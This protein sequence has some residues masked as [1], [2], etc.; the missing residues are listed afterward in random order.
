[1]KKIDIIYFK[2]YLSFFIL[3]SLALVSCDKTKIQFGQA[4]VDN[5]YSNIILV[6]TLTTELSTVYFDSLPTSGSGIMLVG[7]YNDN[8]F[9]KVAAKSFL[10]IQPPVVNDL[11]VN[12]VYDSL[13]LIIKPNKSYYGDTS[14]NSELAVY[15]L[16][17]Q[18]TLPQGQAYFYNTTDF[19][20]NPFPLADINIL[21]SPNNTD[22]IPIRLDDGFGQNL[23]DLYKAQDYVMQSPNNFINFFKGL[24]L[25]ASAGNMHAVYGFKDS[26]IM[27]M[28]YHETNVFN[29]SKYLDFTFYDNDNS[30]FNQVKADR[31]GTP[32]TAFGGSNKEVASSNTNNEAY[33]QNLTGFLPKVKF[34][35]LRGLLLR[36]DFVK[37]LKAEL[38]VKPLKDSYNSITPLPPILYVSPTDQSNILGTP[39]SVRGSSGIVTAQT[40]N[41]MIDP[42][43]QENTEYSYDIT[44]YLQQLILVSSYN[45]NGLLIA[46]PPSVNVST[47]NRTIIGD[48]K[49][50]QGGLQLKIYYV[51]INP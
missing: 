43:Y 47:L 42:I 45:Q 36:P 28:Y 27:R 20:V 1:M 39:L 12:S 49:N 26:L 11:A 30:Q 10:E 44:S 22:S 33:L 4:F 15:Q 46:P 41:L 6:D 19:P 18:L 17:N 34:P 25:S 50:T 16:N 14:F 8:F 37:I 51:S 31:S 24:Q 38:I 9:G 32:L 40:G 3:L 35:T 48:Q 13:V 29:E 5:S 2:S 7:N 23:F 21:I